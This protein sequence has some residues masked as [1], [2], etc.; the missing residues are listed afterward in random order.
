MSFFI[1]MSFLTNGENDDFC[2]KLSRAL[3]FLS[4]IMVCD[5]EELFKVKSIPNS[6]NI[7]LSELNVLIETALIPYHIVKSLNIIPKKVKYL[8]ELN[9]CGK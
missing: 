6:C 8:L 3:P 9:T 4:Q 1:K 7:D 2:D 5:T